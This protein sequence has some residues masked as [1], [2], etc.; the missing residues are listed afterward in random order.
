MAEPVQ[1]PGLGAAF[2]SWWLLPPA[3]AGWHS[4]GHKGA[5]QHPG[6]CLSLYPRPA[7][8]PAGRFGVGTQR[9]HGTGTGLVALL[10][11]PPTHQ[12]GI[13]HAASKRC[14]SDRQAGTTGTAGMEW[15]W[16]AG[17][18][19][20]GLGNACWGPPAPWAVQWGCPAPGHR[21]RP[22][23]PGQVPVGARCQLPAPPLP[24]EEGS[25]AG[26]GPGGDLI[27]PCATP[28]EQGGPHWGELRLESG[29]SGWGQRG[30][31]A[32]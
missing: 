3:G 23:V 16:A 18:R 4:E 19:P 20:P 17:H 31:K 30:G 12:G 28:G 32:L 8:H 1:Q 11:V 14:H 22:H 25:V 7:E 24:G 6:S 13:C 10:G 21:D 9:A 5:G 27:R 15:E 2:G 29:V 26:L